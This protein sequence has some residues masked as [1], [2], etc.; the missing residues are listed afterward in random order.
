MLAAGDPCKS[1]ARAVCFLSWGG[2]VGH[3]LAALAADQLR[4]WHLMAWLPLQLISS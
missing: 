1:R 2:W 4:R 3:G